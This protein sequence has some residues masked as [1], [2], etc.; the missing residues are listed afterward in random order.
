MRNRR[1]LGQVDERYLKQSEA[2][3]FG[4]LAVALGVEPAEVPGFITARV[5]SLDA[6]LD[7][8]AAG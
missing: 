4:E 3:L 5:G 6:Q 2:L 1:R 7:R 8:M